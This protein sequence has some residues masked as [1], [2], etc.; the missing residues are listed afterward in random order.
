MKKIFKDWTVWIVIACGI[1]NIIIDLDQRDWTE[2][3]WVFLASAL[4]VSG[5]VQNLCLDKAIRF[6]D[7]QD[8]LLTKADVIIKAQTE[9]IKELE[10]K[11]NGE[12]QSN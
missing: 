7:E 8:D 3:L 10:E 1:L 5:K 2:A 11:L 12:N 6:I 9:V 4:F